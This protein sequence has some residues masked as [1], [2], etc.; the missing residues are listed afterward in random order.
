MFQAQA[1][2]LW[3]PGSSG[4]GGSS[5]PADSAIVI[6]SMMPLDAT[7]AAAGNAKLEI[8]T[9]YPFGDTAT[10]KVT[11]SKATATTVKIRIP[12]WAV[13][14]TV[15][16]KATA[17]GTLVA[18]LCPAGSTTTIKVDFAPAVVVEREWGSTSAVAV[19][20]G[21]IVRNTIPP[22]FQFI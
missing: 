16:G 10:V 1:T 8:A 6:A 18:T 11:T 21:A 12:T 15:D 9:T 14:A 4:G 20:R 2:V 19:V 3:E 7:V 13:K 22:A 5:T 17:N